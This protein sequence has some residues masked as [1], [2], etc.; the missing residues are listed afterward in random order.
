LTEKSYI[1]KG[2]SLLNFLGKND[3]NLKILQKAFPGKIVVRG[4]KL[5]LIGEERDISRFE[6]GLTSLLS[7][8]KKGIEVDRAT[9][10]SLFISKEMDQK[11]E[12]LVIKVPKKKIR[13]RTPGQND[14]LRAIEGND[15]VI[16]IGP[17][18]TGKTYLAVAK[19]V[20]NLVLKKYERIILVRPAVEAGETLGFLP[21]DFMEKIAPFLRPLYDAL[22]D[23]VPRDKLTRLY[24]T[25]TVEV[26]PLAFMRGRTLNDAFVILDEAQNTTSVQMKMFLTRLGD[27]SKA[28]VTGDITQID[29]PSEQSSGLKKI[30]KILD[31]VKGVEFIYLTK[32]DVV[33]RRL[34]QK[35]VEA[36]EKYSDENKE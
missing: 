35:I 24:D 14:Y 22:I 30:Q 29:L 12:Q 36:Y 25:Q 17:S 16:C 5:L 3:D 34:V 28:V 7:M 31:R 26:A 20:Q 19:A 9:I 23:M 18:G 13:P 27:G 10:E 21:G 2:F 6:P 33:R 8:A 1:L 4:E 15:I 11:E 32:K